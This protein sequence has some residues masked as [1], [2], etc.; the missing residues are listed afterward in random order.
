MS[1][2]YNRLRQATGSGTV[3]DPLTNIPGL[4]LAQYLSAIKNRKINNEAQPQN[5]EYNG[6][7]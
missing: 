4:S 2:E 5:E 3:Y 7:G 1:G 6:L